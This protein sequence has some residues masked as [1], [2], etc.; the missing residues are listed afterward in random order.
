MKFGEFIECIKHQ[1]SLKITISHPLIDKLIS[2]EGML[3]KGYRMSLK[4]ELNIGMELDDFL[5]IISGNFLPND[6]IKVFSEGEF[7]LK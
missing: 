1:P 2:T 6:L 5:T 4:E 3:P 7:Y